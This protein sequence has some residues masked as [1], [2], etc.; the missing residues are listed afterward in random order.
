[1]NIEN[2]QKELKSGISLTVCSED[3]LEYSQHP[4]GEA[5]LNSE[6]DKITTKSNIKR[7][8]KVICSVCGKKYT[9][10]N[11]SHHNKSQIHQL[12]AQMSDK[13]KRVLLKG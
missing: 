8:D 11:R 10:W 4:I 5:I 6:P 12:H 3:T 7:S 2:A 13:M 1:M 9:K